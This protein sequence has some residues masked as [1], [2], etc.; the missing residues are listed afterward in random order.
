MFLCQQHELYGLKQFGAVREPSHIYPGK[1]HEHDI[2]A[3]VECEMV[4][5][6]KEEHSTNSSKH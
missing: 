4:K 1:C 5:F 6:W 2:I 3:S